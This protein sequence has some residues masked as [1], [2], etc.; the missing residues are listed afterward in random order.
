MQLERAL[1]Y[2]ALVPAQPTLSSLRALPFLY[3]PVSTRMGT[4]QAFVFIYF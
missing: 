1:S 4:V 3:P 2:L